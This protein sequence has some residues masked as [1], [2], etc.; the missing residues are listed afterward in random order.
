MTSDPEVDL[1]IPAFLNRSQQQK[2]EQMHTDPAQRVT[3]TET[4]AVSKPEA[5]QAQA[6]MLAETASTVQGAPIQGEKDETTDLSEEQL[7]AKIKEM[8][9]QRATL[10]VAIPKF[11]KALSNR[12]KGM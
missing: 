6:A 1:T 7:M 12:I 10:D 5:E 3:A 4:P 8:V 9:A 11:K 2:E